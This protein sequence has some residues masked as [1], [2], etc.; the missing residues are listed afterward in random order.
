M[1]TMGIEVRDASFDAEVGRSAIPVVLEFFATWCGNC[2]R[3]APVLAA[4]AHE[5]EG[6]VRFLTV[7]AEEN[8]VLVTRFGV[9]S[10]PTI[11]ALNGTWPVGSVVGAQ[12]EKV[13]RELFEL[14]EDR[15]RQESQLSWVP[16]E[17]CTLP[18]EDQ[19][20]RLAEFDELF[21]SSLRSVERGGNTWL[22]LRLEGA[23][24]ERARNLTARETDCCDFFHF[25]VRHGG[26]EVLI[27][28]R[29]PSGRASVLDGLERQARTAGTRT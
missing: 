23:A 2:R 19:P 4:L 24:E 26:D 28:V 13:L 25:D 20:L 16:A 3:V 10:T 22:R 5:F 12:P 29:V 27:D 17:A 18:T 1:R 11:L 6:R 8:P 21:T 7:N 9:T 14:A 15:D